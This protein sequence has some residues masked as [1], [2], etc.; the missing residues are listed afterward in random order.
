VAYDTE[1]DQNSGHPAGQ[2]V[3]AMKQDIM[4]GHKYKMAYAQ[5]GIKY[6]GKCTKQQKAQNGRCTK[7]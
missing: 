6:N 3:L 7:H 1:Q 4:K 5:N 2:M